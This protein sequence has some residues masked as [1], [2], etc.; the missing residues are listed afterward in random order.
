MYAARKPLVFAKFLN[1]KQAFA[2][3]ALGGYYGHNNRRRIFFILLS[4]DVAAV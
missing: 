3:K 4:Y 2:E 1:G